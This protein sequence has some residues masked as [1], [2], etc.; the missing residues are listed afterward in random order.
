MIAEVSARGLSEL[1]RMMRLFG[2]Q[3]LDKIKGTDGVERQ[4]ST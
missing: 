4:R 2:R 1:K 3:E